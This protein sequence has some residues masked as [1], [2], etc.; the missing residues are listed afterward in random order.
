MVLQRA[1][2][3]AGDGRHRGSK[4]T[5]TSDVVIVSRRLLMAA[6]VLFGACL[7]GSPGHAQSGPFAGMA[8]RWAGG[9]TVTLDDGSTERIRCRAIY[10]VGGP[11][12][13]LTLTCASDTYK[14]DL[15]GEVVAGPNGVIR[16]TWSESSRNVTGNLQGRGRGGSFQVVANGPGFDANIS[17]V[18]RG[19]R[20]S[21]VMRAANQFRGAS[22]SLSR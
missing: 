19:N 15:H 6:A 12:M 3:A 14:F 21:I 9:G 22:I 16:G 18:T 20:Q 11:Q 5:A 2:R 4:I 1:Y 10:A 13:N 17:L 7:F 8:G